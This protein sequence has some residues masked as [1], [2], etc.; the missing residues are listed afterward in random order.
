VTTI[1]GWND[2]D[3]SPYELRRHGVGADTDFAHFQVRAHISPLH[4]R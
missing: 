3:V 1:H 2:A 4:P